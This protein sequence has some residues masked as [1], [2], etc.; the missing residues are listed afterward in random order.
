MED[1]GEVRLVQPL[2]NNSLGD[3]LSP[4]WQEQMTGNSRSRRRKPSRGPGVINQRFFVKLKSSKTLQLT[5]H[6][7]IYLVQST[8]L[9][10]SM[11]TF[12]HAVA[13][14]CQLL[15]AELK[16]EPYCITLALVKVEHKTDALE[17]S[18]C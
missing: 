16:P 17:E 6:A 9:Q 18:G 7:H 11:T 10:K 14:V 3:S 8:A 12:H 2:C 1:W 5:S 4:W 13:V 15:R